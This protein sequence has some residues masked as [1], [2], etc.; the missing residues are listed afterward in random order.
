MGDANLDGRLVSMEKD[1]PFSQ[2]LEDKS[3]EYFHRSFEAKR[4]NK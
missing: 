4:V 2:A 1:G 3:F